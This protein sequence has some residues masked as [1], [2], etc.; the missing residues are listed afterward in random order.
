[1]LLIFC[2]INLFL[3]ENC[4]VVTLG[5]NLEIPPSR[6]DEIEDVLSKSKI[7]LIQSEI[8]QETNLRVFEV[9]RKHGGESFF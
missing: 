1:M 3:S 5:A 2:L 9:A 7:V 4:I 8:P 6:V